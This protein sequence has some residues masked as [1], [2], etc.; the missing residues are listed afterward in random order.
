MGRYPAPHLDYTST[1]PPGSLLPLA[2]V[3]VHALGIETLSPAIQQVAVLAAPGSTISERNKSWNYGNTQWEG[4]RHRG[5]DSVPIFG[6]A[7]KDAVITCS[8]QDWYGSN[9]AQD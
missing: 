5:R 1:S 4:V 9:R 2:K 7:N 3:A 6:N 8:Y